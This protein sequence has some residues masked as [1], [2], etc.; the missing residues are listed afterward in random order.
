MENKKITGKEIWKS[1]EIQ[2]QFFNECS[3]LIKEFKEKLEEYDPKMD[4]IKKEILDV[5]SSL[6]SVDVWSPDAIQLTYQKVDEVVCI[7]IILRDGTFKKNIGI[8]NEPL[9]TYSRL[10]SNNLKS[11][12]GF[13]KVWANWRIITELNP[14]NLQNL[15]KST[16][17]DLP[18][19]EFNKIKNLKWIESGK[20]KAKKL[21]DIKNKGDINDIVEEIKKWQV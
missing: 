6:N 2:Q 11:V 12:D 17:I 4:L 7:N 18:K 9:I 14:E 21:F 13:D 3:L 10:K 5:S 20:L 15:I 19:P 16:T 1:F 8:F